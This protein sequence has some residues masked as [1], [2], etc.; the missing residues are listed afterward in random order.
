MDQAPS[1]KD[2]R[3]RVSVLFDAVRVRELISVL[4]ACEDSGAR[5]IVFKGAALAHTHY[6]ESWQ[7]PRADADLLIAVDSRDRVFATLQARGYTRGTFI[8]GDLVM[9]QAPF[10]RVDHL[11]VDHLLD[12]HWRI[13]NPQVVSQVLTHAELVERS[14]TVS[15]Q[16]YPVRVPSPVDALLLACIHR[17]AHHPDLEKPVWIEDIHRLASRFDLGEWQTFVERATRGSVRRMCLQ[18]LTR[19]HERFQTVVPL[20][21]L[22]ALSAG[23][24]EPSSVFLRAD[25]RPVD[26]LISDLRALRPLGAARLLFEHLFPPVEYMRAAYGVSS[27]AWLPACYVAR[28]WNGMSKWWRP[29]VSAAR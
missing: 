24:G 9:Y 23:H 18:G 29:Y 25:L 8:S 19:A 5:P 3:D 21:V 10:E 14:V 13:V 16:G 15:V 20:N 26:R 4:R 27:G 7:R 22:Q 2:Q 1:T 12:V 11:G 6:A 17:V 28:L